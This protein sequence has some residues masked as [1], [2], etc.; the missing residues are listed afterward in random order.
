MYYFDFE[1]MLM[2]VAV[3]WVSIF[4]PLF[5]IMCFFLS[6]FAISQPILSFFDFLFWLSSLICSEIHKNQLFSGSK[7]F[8]RFLSLS[9]DDTVSLYVWNNL[10]KKS[11]TPDNRLLKVLGTSYS[12]I[13][14]Y[15]PC[16]RVFLGSLILFIQILISRTRH[17]FRSF[18][19]V[20]NELT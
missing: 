6:C 16:T 13:N 4:A 14:I 18:S 3:S 2:W 5:L 11:Y 15:L 9:F 20:K 7:H 12:A 17:S 8:L 1:Y 19:K 10:W